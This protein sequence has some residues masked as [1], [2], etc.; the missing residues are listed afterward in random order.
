MTVAIQIPLILIRNS[1]N[2]LVLS[3]SSTLKEIRKRSQHLLKLAKIEEIQEFEI[4]IGSIKEFRNEGEI[5][6]ALERISGIQERLKEVFFLFDDHRLEA[7]K[8]IK[9]ISEGSYQKAID[10]F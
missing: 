9:L 8:A 6:L 4:D 10:I 7:H 3:S 5:R 1:F 2:I